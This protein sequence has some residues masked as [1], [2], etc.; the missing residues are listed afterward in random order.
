MAL[1]A[2]VAAGCPAPPRRGPRRCWP[3]PACCGPR[4]RSRRGGGG[5]AAGGGLAQASPR[6]WRGWP[7]RA[8]EGAQA[9][10]HPGHAARRDRGAVRARRGGGGRAAGGA[11][12][13]AAR[14]CW[15]SCWRA[16]AGCRRTGWRRR[17]R[18]SP[19]SSDVREELDRLGAHLSARALLAE[20][21]ADRAQARVPD[22]GVR[23]GG[24]HARR[25]VGQPGADADRARPEGGD[26]AAA[27]AGGE[28]RMSADA[29]GAASAWCCAAP[30]GA[31]K[32]SVARALLEAG[33]GPLPLG[34]S[35]TTR[36][37][38]PGGGGGGALL[39]PGAPGFRGMVAAGHMLE[40]ADSTGGATARRACRWS[41]PWRRGGTCCSTSTG[42]GTGSCARRC[43]R[44][45]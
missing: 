23:A 20:G 13:A 33:A 43:R 10:R 28:R 36:A 27:R 40:H 44:M 26:R 2:G 1:A 32:S 12:G 11:P 9:G 45:W 37:A 24:E 16:S 35:A 7:A 14:A 41:R 34:F 38:R 39:L 4:W 22:P 42:R 3:C 8:G 29:A 18:C 30:S 6:R 21:G 25:E 5:G 15:R 17:S 19:R 31:G